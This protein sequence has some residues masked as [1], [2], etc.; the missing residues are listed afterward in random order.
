MFLVKIFMTEVPWELP[1][2][3]EG[4]GIEELMQNEGIWSWAA[5]KLY[6]HIHT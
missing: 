2:R 1:R 5:Q 3:L 6:I 4:E